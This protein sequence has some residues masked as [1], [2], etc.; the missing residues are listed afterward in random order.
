MNHEGK[1]NAVSK[2]EDTFSPLWLP[3]DSDSMIEVD[4]TVFTGTGQ[5]PEEQVV[6]VLFTR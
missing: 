5:K 3:V 2:C 1:A 6:T 4:F